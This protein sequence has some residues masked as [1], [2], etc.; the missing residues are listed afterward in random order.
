MGAIA[1]TLR[2]WRTVLQME[3]KDRTIIPQ[4]QLLR[5][6]GQYRRLLRRGVD[7]AAELHAAIKQAREDLK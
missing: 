5:A 2:P 4:W 6:E 3:N 7:D 1:P